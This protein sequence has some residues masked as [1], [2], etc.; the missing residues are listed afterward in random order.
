[1]SPGTVQSAIC[2]HMPMYGLTRTKKMGIQPTSSVPN[3]T[4]QVKT[5]FT[6]T[7]HPLLSRSSFYNKTAFIATLK[8]LMDSLTNE[9]SCAFFESEEDTPVTLIALNNAIQMAQEITKLKK[10]ISEA[11][12]VKGHINN[13]QNIHPTHHAIPDGHVCCEQS[14][15]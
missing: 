3:L 10:D 13:I 4:D 11:T 6:Q 9:S 1:M 5:L 8:T 14:Y 2:I 15:P 7:L 12:L